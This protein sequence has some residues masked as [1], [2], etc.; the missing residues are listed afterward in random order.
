MAAP[1]KAVSDAELAVGYFE[2]LIASHGE[3]W[4]CDN[5]TRL[6]IE[7]AFVSDSLDPHMPP[8]RGWGA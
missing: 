2:D 8:R 3:R 7:A 5:W 4:V 6:L 1:Q